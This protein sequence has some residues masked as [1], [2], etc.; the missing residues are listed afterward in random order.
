[1][2][3]DFEHISKVYEVVKIQNKIWSA[4]LEQNLLR[5]FIKNEYKV[6]KRF[7]K[8]NEITLVLEKIR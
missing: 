2:T 3:I 8:N 7:L 5:I 6:I 4:F 1:M